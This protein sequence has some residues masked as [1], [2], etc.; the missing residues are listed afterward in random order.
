[1][2]LACHELDPVVDQIGV[3]VL[4]LLLAELHLL[5]PGDDVVVGEKP[6]LLSVLNELV[7]LLD[8]GQ[9]D[10]DREQE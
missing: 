1:M 2:R 10:V 3:E 4:D 6:F 5:E 7:Q 8:V 9:R